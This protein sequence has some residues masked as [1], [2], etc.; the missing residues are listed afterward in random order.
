MLP[1]PGCGPTVAAAAAARYDSVCPGTRPS[2]HVAR[3][4]DESL[5]TSR[6]LTTRHLPPAVDSRGRF[7]MRR[8]CPSLIAARTRRSEQLRNRRKVG[9]ATAA[10]RQVEGQLEA[11]PLWPPTTVSGARRDDD[12]IDMETS[13]RHS[14]P[15][16]TITI[17]PALRPRV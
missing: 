3:R 9:A 12:V 16:I 17:Y 2:R 11:T 6:T 5:M 1:C 13:C 14:P 10:S 15:D 7:L 8:S 4:D